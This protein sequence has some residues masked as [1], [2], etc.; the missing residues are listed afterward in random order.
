[1]AIQH[2]TGDEEK[3]DNKSTTLIKIHLIGFI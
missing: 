2:M 1:M 3:L